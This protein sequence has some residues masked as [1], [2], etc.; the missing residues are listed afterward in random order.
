MVSFFSKIRYQ[1]HFPFTRQLQCL[2]NEDHSSQ[3]NPCCFD[4]KCAH[5]K[6]LKSLQSP[7]LFDDQTSY[8]TINLQ[9][10]SWH[11]DI[12]GNCLADELSRTGTTLQLTSEK[13]EICML[14]PN[15]KHLIS[16]HVINLAWS[17]WRQSLTCS[18]SRQTWQEWSMSRTNRLLKFKRNRKFI[19]TLV[20]VLIDHCL[21]GRHAS[22]LGAPY[23]DYCRM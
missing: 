13:D 2:P 6:A 19:G 4:K 8:L 9:W 7:M 22:R 17:R 1:N 18:T 21:I 16:E 11:S 5:N 14:L 23:N 3:R 10:V 20:G 12:P 15:C